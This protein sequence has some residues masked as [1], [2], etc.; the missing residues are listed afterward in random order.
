MRRLAIFKTNAFFVG[1]AKGMLVN[2]DDVV[3]EDRPEEEALNKNDSS[4]SDR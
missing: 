4:G 3:N 2:E 1:E